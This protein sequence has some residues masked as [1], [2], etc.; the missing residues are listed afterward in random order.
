M[1]L[2]NWSAFRIHKFPPLCREGNRTEYQVCVFGL[3]QGL[4]LTV[5]LGMLRKMKRVLVYIIQFFQYGVDYLL[6][7]RK[8]FVLISEISISKKSSSNS[9]VT[10]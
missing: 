8:G 7:S 5:A 9:R 6:R 4:A 3:L 1:T 2:E 10:W